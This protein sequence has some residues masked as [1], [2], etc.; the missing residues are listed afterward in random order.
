MLSKADA[1]KL[2][3]LLKNI[4]VNLT[5]HI[6]SLT[7]LNDI[8]S[9]YRNPKIR[10]QRTSQAK[11]LLVLIACCHQFLESLPTYCS[12]VAN[13]V[14]ELILLLADNQFEQEGR[15]ADL[16]GVPA[17]TLEELVLFRS[18]LFKIRPIPSLET[19]SLSPSKRLRDKVKAMTPKCSAMEGLDSM[20][21]QS[22]I[23]PC[24]VRT[25]CEAEVKSYLSNSMSEYDEDMLGN[26]SVDG[27]YEHLKK[28]AAKDGEAMLLGLFHKCIALDNEIPELEYRHVVA[29]ADQFT[30][31][32][33]D[34]LSK[35]E[36]H[37][38]LFC[39]FEL[40]KPFNSPLILPAVMKRLT[41]F[42]K[43]VGIVEAG[44]GSAI[45]VNDLMALATKD[46]E[47]AVEYLQATVEKN[48]QDRL[49]QQLFVVLHF[50]SQLIAWLESSRNPASHLPLEVLF[51]LL[52]F[53][54][55][56][57]IQYANNDFMRSVVQPMLFVLDF[58]QSEAQVTAVELERIYALIQ[59]D[60][61]VRIDIKSNTP[62][63]R[64]EFSR[65]WQY[66]CFEDPRLQPLHFGKILPRFLDYL[67]GGEARIVIDEAFHTLFRVID[68]GVLAPKLVKDF[69]H[70]TIK[71][72]GV[73]HPEFYD[74]IKR[75]AL[76]NAY[77]AMAMLN[78]EPDLVKQIADCSPIFLA[79]MLINHIEA[80]AAIAKALLCDRYS[81]L[82][83]LSGGYLYYVQQQLAAK[84]IELLKYLP[85]QSVYFH[86]LQ[87]VEFVLS[88]SNSMSEHTDDA[89]IL[90]LRALP[91]DMYFLKTLAVCFEQRSVEI[92]ERLATL[93]IAEISTPNDL[94]DANRLGISWKD[95]LIPHRQLAIAFV[96]R[97]ELVNALSDDN[98]MELLTTSTADIDLLFARCR[99]VNWDCIAKLATMYRSITIST[100]FQLLTLV[101]RQAMFSAV[102]SRSD[103]NLSQMTQLT[104]DMSEEQNDDDLPIGA[105]DEEESTIAEKLKLMTDNHADIPGRRVYKAMAVDHDFALKVLQESEWWHMYLHPFAIYFLFEHYS[106]GSEFCELLLQRMYRIKLAPAS[107]F[108]STNEKIPYWQDFMFLF[109]EGN[110]LSFEKFKESLCGCLS[111]FYLKENKIH[112]AMLYALNSVESVYNEQAYRFVGSLSTLRLRANEVQNYSLETGAV[113]CVLKTM[114]RRHLFGMLNAAITQLPHSS[115][116]L[117]ISYLTVDLEKLVD[118]DFYDKQ[119]QVFAIVIADAL[120][121]L[122]RYS[123]AGQTTYKLTIDAVMSLDKPPI[124]LASL[125]QALQ[126]EVVIIADLKN[127]LTRVLHALRPRI[128]QNANAHV[129]YRRLLIEAAGTNILN[130]DI[131][132]VDHKHSVWVKF[133]SLRLLFPQKKSVDNELL[134][135]MVNYLLTLHAKCYF[136]YWQI[137]EALPLWLSAKLQGLSALALLLEF[138]SSRRFDKYQLLTEVAVIEN[139]FVDQGL[140]SGVTGRVN[141]YFKKVKLAISTPNSPNLHE[142][143]ENRYCLR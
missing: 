97:E 29:L 18:K 73:R 103:L 66:K 71:A 45:Y 31:V 64:A 142:V 84:H 51:G 121:Y 74:L 99:G 128:L 33:L 11:Y 49:Q 21:A 32:R 140:F 5:E 78:D 113:C 19:R 41:G 130:T 117:F 67:A 129:F 13:L 118:W 110:T 46:M 43:S 6:S 24:S 101:P 139:R 131:F 87:A 56:K 95:L 112:L 132:G 26:L 16:V 3:R 44:D 100:G 85:E 93:L 69:F 91:F 60:I 120:R 14:A 109:N 54:E 65:F 115:R 75:F 88:L 79:V 70:Q 134:D 2:Q 92:N 136:D 63:R 10:G 38:K 47:S 62:I 83:C 108:D 82:S 96:Q 127:A 53:I 94:I 36:N 37:R 86:R 119:I 126:G 102:H 8:N 1:E 9:L 133:S 106:P 135:D 39:Q 55:S 42:A 57:R 143:Q 22:Q 125:L 98:Q 138:K 104:F 52:K 105:V 40:R 30:I 59:H 28:I 23:S 107:V 34:Q 81:S 68:S 77:Y 20:D 116:I 61:P 25:D 111:Y 27:L 15:L 7:T 4:A 89:I 80:D 114:L 12:I 72:M 123:R 124:Y 50:P 58:F 48:D 122:W 35:L 90:Q 76:N 141:G 17:E 137:G